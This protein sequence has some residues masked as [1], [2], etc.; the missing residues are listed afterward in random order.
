MDKKID[1][2][3]NLNHKLNKS[4][5]IKK[6]LSRDSLITSDINKSIKSKNNKFNYMNSISDKSLNKKIK[7]QIESNSSFSSQNNKSQIKKLIKSKPK[8][9]NNKK[10]FDKIIV[11]N[12][13]NIYLNITKLPNKLLKQRI[14]LLIISFYVSCIHW[15]FLFLSKRKI[16]RDYCFTSLNQFE[17][18]T[19]EQYCS[20][21]VVSQINYQQINS[22]YIKLN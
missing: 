12:I 10:V 3:K 16:E 22:I 5:N 2:D 11:D 17:V 9:N 14:F 19:E 7:K 4:K 21:N 6:D 15:T 1:E 13:E 8:N 20:Q 18:C